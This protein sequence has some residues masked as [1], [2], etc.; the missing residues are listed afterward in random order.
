M[1]ALP[2]RAFSRIHHSVLVGRG[3]GVSSFGWGRATTCETL[4]WDAILRRNDLRCCGNANS[5]H[6]SKLDIRAHTGGLDAHPPRLR[7]KA[8]SMKNG[9]WRIRFYARVMVN[10]WLLSWLTARSLGFG[11]II[12]RQRRQIAERYPSGLFC[13]PSSFSQAVVS[14]SHQRREKIT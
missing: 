11:N 14:V 1:M 6:R 13:K 4:W 7:A 3:S 5:G 12:F 2:T 9:S 10:Q 8:N